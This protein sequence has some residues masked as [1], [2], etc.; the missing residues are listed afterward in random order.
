[1]DKKSSTFHRL[2][3]NVYKAAQNKKCRPWAALCF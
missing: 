2:F 1:M 3:V